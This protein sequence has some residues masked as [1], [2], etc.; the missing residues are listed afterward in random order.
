MPQIIEVPG[1]GRVEFPDGMSDE[2][3]VSA[4]RKLSPA[5]AQPTSPADGVGAWHAGL[6]A[7]GR[8]TDKVVK[9]AQQ[10]YYGAMGNDKALAALKAESESDDAAYEPLQKARPIATGIGEMV[11]AMAVPIGGGVGVF[12]KMGRAA[13]GGAIP[14]AL[15]YGDAGERASGALTG[16]L[17]NMAGASLGMGVTKMMQPANRAAS[18][19]KEALGAADR[20]GLNLTA[21]Q[22]TQNPALMNFENYLSRSPGSSGAMQATSGAQQ[23][24]LNKAAAKAMGQSADDLSEGVFA[25][26]KDGIGKEF[27]RLQGIT[28][29]KI[30]NDFMQTLATIDA[31]NMAKGA[32]RSKS[33]DSLIDKSL[34]LAQQGNLSGKAYKEIRT[35]LSNEAT[36]AFKAGD[37]SLGQAYKSVRTAL[38][39]AAKDSLSAA[40]KKAWDTSR[41]QWQAYKELTRSN[42]AEGGNVSAARLAAG[43]RRGGDGLRTG[44]ATGGLADIARIGEAIKGAQNPN[45]G[46][47]IQNMMFGNPIT[48][49]P[50]A[51]GNKAAQWAYSSRPAQKY[52]EKGLLSLNPTSEALLLQASLPLGGPLVGGLLGTR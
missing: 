7:A 22:R 37:A 8:S 21:G 42:V 34:D 51:A 38:D 50:M 14:G 43:I 39:A 33:V 17:S 32:F 40:D 3:I 16:A 35:Q 2:A 5:Q 47:L 18:I 1:Q 15:S 41:A 24:A 36:A 29:P 25:A 4:I 49:L 31:D 20:L 52:M 19:S 6:I 44:Q 10:L 30:G 45:S 13:L 23:Q 48:A 28:A 9:G 12:G 26:A 46:N 11:P 27:T